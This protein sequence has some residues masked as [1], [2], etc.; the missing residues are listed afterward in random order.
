MEIKLHDAMRTL[1]IPR[2]F[3][4]I[5][6]LA[7]MT[8][9]ATLTAPSFAAA[10]SSDAVAAYA[11]AA[12]TQLPERARS[13]LEAIDAGPRRVLATQAYL[14]SDGA[15][16]TRWSWSDREI[17]EYERSSDFQAMN[18]AVARVNARF[19]AQNPGYS[20]AVNTQV[21]SLDLQ[22]QRWNEN[23]GVGRA[24]ERICSMARDELRNGKYPAT[25]N[26]AATQRFI[27][28]L[29]S[30]S[31]AAPLAAPGLSLHGQARAM[32]FQ[33]R[34]GN[35]TVAGPEVASVAD[36]WEKQ[37]W[38]RRLE[39]AIDPA[40]GVFVG[41]LRQPNEPWHYEYVGDMRRCRDQCLH[42]SSDKD[43][44]LR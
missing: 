27:A 28:F 38:A 10:A 40:Q 43:G 20:L 37:G 1:A 19:Q 25:P 6:G 9:F 31:A 24:A 32:D 39:Q 33:V 5:M 12:A 2:G 21:R 30:L 14:R 4:A 41:P 44:E 26:A 22:L 29:K 36:V 35:G 11:T 3:V 18:A 17:A 34:N 16:L 8:G 23:P 15:L 13:A 42:A 7:V